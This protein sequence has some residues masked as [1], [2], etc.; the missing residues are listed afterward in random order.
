MCFGKSNSDFASASGRL[1]RVDKNDKRSVI[2]RDLFAKEADTSKFTGLKAPP[3]PH[4]GHAWT[5]PD[6]LFLNA[7]KTC[8]PQIHEIE[9]L[10]TQY[11]RA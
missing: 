1:D 2:I 10:F 8:T 5:T 9:Y 7:L 11:Y 4:Q 3:R 6:P